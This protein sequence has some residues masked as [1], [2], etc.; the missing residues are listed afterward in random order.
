MGHL[1]EGQCGFW[2]LRDQCS[3]LC[4][5]IY[6]LWDLEK[7][8]SEAQFLLL[9]GE[10]KKNIDKVCGIVS[11]MGANSVQGFVCS[12]HLIYGN[13]KGLSMIGK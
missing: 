9:Q 8:I 11:R 5:V 1:R 2:I 4:S 13:D 3:N 6:N 12:K 7:F 10:D